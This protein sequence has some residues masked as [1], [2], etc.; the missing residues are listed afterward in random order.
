MK[1]E[2]CQLVIL[3]AGSALP[4]GNLR[5][6]GYLL[7][8]QT[9]GYLLDIGPGTW[10]SLSKYL[11]AHHIHGIFLTHDHIDHILDLGIALFS[12]PLYE[13]WLGK[14]C[15]P[16]IYGSRETIE[17]LRTWFGANRYIRPDVFEWKVLRAGLPYVVSKNLTVIPSCVRHASSSLAYRFDIQQEG[18]PP[19][20][21]VYS[22]DTGW[23]ESFI[24][25][26]HHAHYLLLECSHKKPSQSHLSLRD[27]EWIARW[28]QPE[29]IILSHFYPDVLR[30]VDGYPERFL[31]S[32]L[33]IAREGTTF[34]L[35]KK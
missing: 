16:I 18:K 22:G 12:A 10:H 1:K 30:E 17:S 7:K 6:A 8:F 31:W 4:Q 2:E 24:Q 29:C 32:K 26:A 15:K 23:S 13:K 34:I 27:I 14:A 33:F 11:P 9:H 5:P 21:F 20:H 19:L 25:L 35:T 28:I 3:G